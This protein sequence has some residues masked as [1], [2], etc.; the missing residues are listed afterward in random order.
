MIL[1]A[2]LLLLA[3][4]DDLALEVQNPGGFPSYLT[5]RD[6][7]ASGSALF[8]SFRRVGGVPV[9]DP[10][11]V[12][13]IQ[14]S[15]RAEGA[16]VRLEVGVLF[17][18]FD[19]N[20]TPRSLEGVPRETVGR[21]LIP[22][23]TSARLD[24]LARYGIEPFEVRTVPPKPEVPNLPAIDNRTTALDVVGVGEDRTTYP[25]Q[26]KNISQK[27]VVALELRSPRDRGSS[28]QRGAAKLPRVL[29]APGEIHTVQCSIDRTGRSTSTGFVAD[30]PARQVIVISAVVFDDGSW[31]GE[32]ETAA[33]LLAWLHGFRLQLARIVT[34]LEAL[35]RSGS[36]DPA[37]VRALA[38]GLPEEPSRSEIDAAAARFGALRPEALARELHQSLRLRRDQLLSLLKDYDRNPGVELRNW[39]E[40]RIEQYREELRAL[41]AMGQ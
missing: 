7:A 2:A 12:T 24:D 31:D 36:N 39:L 27:N 37:E 28:G 22:L 34:G 4:A 9:D 40:P 6:S 14:M 1:A 32:S 11:Y 13:A 30:S 21:Y 35:L 25:V 5:V 38:A 29:I 23:N 20:D 17:G 15:Y 16:A 8:Y 3:A 33:A 18:R 41:A 19:H 26:L 10:R